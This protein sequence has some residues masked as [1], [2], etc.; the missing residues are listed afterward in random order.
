MTNCTTARVLDAQTIAYQVFGTGEHIVL[1]IPGAIGT[2]ASD[3]PAQ[4]PLSLPGGSEVVREPHSIG[5]RL[6]TVHF[7]FVAVQLPG[8]GQSTPPGRLL[9]PN[10]Y[11]HDAHCCMALMEVNG[12][13]SCDFLKHLFGLILFDSSTSA[14]DTTPSLAGLTAPRSPS[15]S[16]TFSPRCR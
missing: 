6:D 1:V 8:W 4:L 16:P 2:A 14:T 3:F 12:E 9:G 7:C 15:S 10:T 5:Q 13:D 11:R